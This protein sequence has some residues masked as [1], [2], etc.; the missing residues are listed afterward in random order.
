MGVRIVAAMALLY[1]VWGSTYLAIRVGVESIPPLLA[2]GLRFGV[3]G[4][5][6][7]PLALRARPTKRQVA[8]SSLFGIWLLVGGPGL[9]TVAETHVPSNLAAVLASTTSITVCIWR[10]LAG[11]R[12][13]RMTLV[14][15]A[16]GFVGVV[17]LLIAPVMGASAPVPW[18]VLILFSAALWSTASFY[19][20]G[21]PAVS[22][23]WAAT[24]VQMIAAGAAMTIAGLVIGERPGDVTLRSGVALAYLVVAGTV[25]LA[26]YGYALAHLP[27]STVVTHQYVNPV[28]ALALGALILGESLAALEVT[29]AVLVVGAVF[30]I[31]QAERRGVTAR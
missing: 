13:P 2:A 1:T 10:R 5:I 17:V 20:R 3:A 27:I 31:V 18:M 12:L 7:A 14:G 28:V 30:A 22:G 6:L 26:A 24:T 11:E 23:L 21:L 25:A 9:L 8:G 29:G 4:L 19:G 16:M 15:V